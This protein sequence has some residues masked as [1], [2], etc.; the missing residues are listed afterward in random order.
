MSLN[1]YY[2]NYSSKKNFH[3]VR[4]LAG[5]AVQSQEL[6]A[7]Q[8]HYLDLIQR[9][10]DSLYKNGT[11]LSGCSP[12][13]AG[14]NVTITAGRV[15]IAG[16]PLDLEET[17]L[18]ITP[19]GTTVISLKITRSIVAA[20][21]T[22]TA[23]TDPILKDPSVG[24]PNFGKPGAD[25]EKVVASWTVEAGDVPIFTYINGQLI[26]Q[27][28]REELNMVE[29]VLARRTMDTDGNYLTDGLRVS[30]RAHGTDATKIIP[31]ITAGKA[32][33]EGHEVNRYASADLH[34]AA[35]AG[36][37]YIDKALDGQAAQGLCQYKDE[38]YNAGTKVA[39]MSL[40]ADHVIKGV[41]KVTATWIETFDMSH[42]SYNGTDYFPIDATTN[43]LDILEVRDG[44][45][46]NTVYPTDRYALAGT[47][48][49]D[50][51]TNP[52]ATAGTDEPLNNGGT[53]T[54]KAVVRGIIPHV[55]SQGAVLYSWDDHYLDVGPAI[56]SYP[57]ENLTYL[58]VEYEFY[59]PR[60]DLVQILPAPN[61]GTIEIVKGQADEN[62][63]APQPS[64]NALPIAEIRIPP[65]QT[66]VYAADIDDPSKPYAY[67]ENYGC[68]RVTQRELREM[69]KRL[70][71]QEYNTAVNDL[72]AEAVRRSSTAIKGAFSDAFTSLQKLR[73]TEAQ[74]VLMSVAEGVLK[75]PETVQVSN[76][77]IVTA[78]K[79][80]GKVQASIAS[81]PYSTSKTTVVKAATTDVKLNQY[82][83][84]SDVPHLAAFGNEE[85]FQ[86]TNWQK[87]PAEYQRAT[88][89]IRGIWGEVSDLKV[90]YPSAVSLAKGGYVPYSGAYTF[91]VKGWNYGANTDNLL[92]YA[93]GK[94]GRLVPKNSTLA[95]GTLVQSGTVT[96]SLADPTDKP[97]NGTIVKINLDGAEVSFTVNG[98]NTAADVAGQLASACFSDTTF[99]AKADVVANGAVLTVTL[100]NNVQTLP[101]SVSYD[102]QAEVV[103][104]STYI[105]LTETGSIKADAKGFFEADFVAPSGIPQ[106]ERQVEIKAGSKTAKARYAV[107]GS[108]SRSISDVPTLEFAAPEC[109][110]AAQTFRAPANPVVGV[111]V[112]FTSAD[113]NYP[114]EVQI[115]EVVNGQPTKRVLARK[116]LFASDL[117]GKISTLTTPIE[118]EVLFDDP[119]VGY[120]GSDLAVVFETGGQQGVATNWGVVCAEVGL[121]DQSSL[122]KPVVAGNPYTY[123]SFF[124]GASAWME[125]PGMDLKWNLIEAVPAGVETIIA[126]D[127][128][129]VTKATSIILRVNQGIPADTSIKWEYKA[130]EDGSWKP[131]FP[132]IEADLKLPSSEGYAAS[133]IW[134]RAV[135]TGG[136]GKFPWFNAKSLRLVAC[137]RE[138]DGTYQSVSVPVLFTSAT[139]YIETQ[140]VA[141]LGHT[142]TPKIY[143]G[144]ETFTAMVED[145]S[146]R[147][148]MG[149]GYFRRKYTRSDI[150]SGTDFQL[151]ILLHTDAESVSPLIRQL[152]VSVS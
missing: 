32:M 77:S 131:I 109:S 135:L 98:Q 51:G 17:T 110:A 46:T 103:S 133:K 36:G 52:A 127:P 92:G 9:L 122:G 112:F 118:V 78:D 41:T 39:R 76:P 29:N 11:I 72:N 35:A 142:V 64:R 53:Y 18:P 13:P 1:A 96:I 84:F 140:T 86:E 37:L 148:D 66:I 71:K 67:V 48:A 69:L 124:T 93:D 38:Y 54:V 61:L 91:G 102:K 10:G 24:R 108:L 3:F 106:G 116:T 6:N 132:G 85:L 27:G 16:L 125:N 12:I 145:E 4:W 23:T 88:K 129:T 136:S 139:L 20:G 152:V 130:T 40:D 31:S 70:E 111:G 75:L 26:S 5:R 82:G 101:I 15:Y 100:R 47:R 150:N 81:L 19:T 33:V 59:L 149:D 83:T 119:V 115:R 114:L 60:I 89:H 99:N 121:A 151:Q 105:R 147:L 126:F 74:K 28:T 104:A 56:A 7:V 50:W 57:I 97:V 25:R 34:C 146:A 73:N 21:D 94:L 65:G 43:I 55:T 143:T 117:D 44:T 58:D 134:L 90:Q 87:V 22:E 113:P 45:N 30:I 2:N 107:H 128:V 63:H 141:G 68:Y 80:T 144:N 95:G 137:S 79:N 123:G 120:A 8:S 14:A 42:T 138:K 49:I 62:P